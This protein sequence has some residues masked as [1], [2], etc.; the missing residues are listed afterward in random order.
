MGVYFCLEFF[1]FR[2]PSGEG[3]YC[4]FSRCKGMGKEGAEEEGGVGAGY[5]EGGGAGVAVSERVLRL[6]CRS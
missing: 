3:A 6:G 2:E 4:V 5:G 1:F